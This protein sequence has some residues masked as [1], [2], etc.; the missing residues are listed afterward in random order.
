MNDSAPISSIFPHFPRDAEGRPI[1]GNRSPFFPTRR[2]NK[3][4]VVF[5]PP[6]VGKS[7]FI[8]YIVMRT[9]RI[10]AFDLERIGSSDLRSKVATH[11]GSSQPQWPSFIG[12]ADT[13][14][15]CYYPA[16]WVRVLVLPPR[17]LYEARRALRDAQHPE[18]AAQRCSYGSFEDAAALGRYDRVEADFPHLENSGK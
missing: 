4:I 18:K 13:A 2:L 11:I 10:W 16:F 7:T 15:E 17:S 3:G 8:D 9:S 1:C 6:G 12:A 5:G 14:P